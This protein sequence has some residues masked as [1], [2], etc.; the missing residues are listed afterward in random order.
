MI[1]E[2]TRGADFVGLHSYLVDDREYRLLRTIKVSSIEDAGLEMMQTSD[3]APSVRKPVLQLSVSAAPQDF[4]I[5]TTELF[6]T[7]FDE[8]AREFGLD[9][10]QRVEVE[11]LDKPHYRHAH[12]AICVIHPETGEQPPKRYTLVGDTLHAE[13]S[14]SGPLSAAI[15][16]GLQ[17]HEYVVR[18]WDSHMLTRLEILCR[19]FERAHG[20]QQLR[21]PAESA[22]ARRAGAARAP[23][24]ARRL[25]LERT[26]ARPIL[27]DA[28]QLREALNKSTWQARERELGELNIEMQPFF[29]RGADPSRE[30]LGMRLVDKLDSKNHIAASSLD[31]GD[32]KFGLQALEARTLEFT[33]DFKQWCDLPKPPGNQP[34]IKSTCQNLNSLVELRLAFQKARVEARA[35]QAN[36][37]KMRKK[38]SIRHRAERAALSAEISKCRRQFVGPQAQNAK[39]LARELFA[40]THANPERARLHQSQKRE[41]SEIRVMPLGTWPTWL[42]QQAKLGNVVA[43]QALLKMDRSLPH[44]KQT[45]VVPVQTVQ[46][47]TRS[48][49]SPAPA[50]PDVQVPLGAG[51]AQTTSSTAITRPDR[52]ANP[53]TDFDAF[54]AEVARRLSQRGR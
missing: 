42:Q 16:A 45:E 6:E 28:A 2:Y 40:V 1:A 12:A 27:E 20:L 35:A 47:P 29:R 8:I 23:S 25:Y 38:L 3:M 44:L 51:Q 11:H 19:G 24:P 52:S 36:A 4:A 53:Q 33:L 39:R 10:H 15:A 32:H 9:G 5:L 7:L 37:T 13:L 43:T 21:A 54:N 22:A 48:T 30:P 34:S 31:I 14:R 41:R 17:P 49:R 26:G 50:V 46:V 18:T